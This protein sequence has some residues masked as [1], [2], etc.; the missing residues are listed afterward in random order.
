MAQGPMKHEDAVK[1]MAV[2]QY[3]L[4]EMAPEEREAFEEHYFECA[5]CADELKAASSFASNAKAIF[6]ASE[7][8]PKT[9]LVLEQKPKSSWFGWLRPQTAALAFAGVAIVSL[10][11]VATLW[12]QINQY[13]SPRIV[14]SSFLRGQTRGTAP[15]IQAVAGGPVL[16]TFDLPEVQASRLRYLVESSDGKVIFEL[17]GNSPGSGEPVNLFIPKL[18]LPAGNYSVRVRAEGGADGPDLA[19]YPFQLK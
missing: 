18:D 1:I 9:P 6:A 16:L 5:I 14:D 12:H 8:S 10:G 19:R 17:S 13:S 15:V 2:E 11:V 3:L 7:A 4:D